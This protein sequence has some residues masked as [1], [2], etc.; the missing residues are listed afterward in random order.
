[1]PWRSVWGGEGKEK[2]VN[3]EKDVDVQDVHN[4][5]LFRQIL[6]LIYFFL[7]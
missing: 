4:A 6:I 1:M 7:F 5:E 3:V 2:D